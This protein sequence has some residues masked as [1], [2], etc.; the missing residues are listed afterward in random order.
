M[1]GSR[2]RKSE[3]STDGLSTLPRLKGCVRYVAV[4]SILYVMLQV[5]LN[6][7]NIV[8]IKICTFM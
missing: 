7:V 5:L 8:K 6:L 2:H 3:Q 4:R 1:L